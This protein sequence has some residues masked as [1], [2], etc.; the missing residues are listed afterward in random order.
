[1]ADKRSEILHDVSQ[2]KPLS[3]SATALLDVASKEEHDLQ[4]LVNIV[5]HDAT[6]T[7]EIL[8]VVNSAAYGFDTEITAIDRAISFTGE[9]A[10]VSLAMKEAAAI[11]F[12]TDLSGYAGQKGDLWDH[13]LFTA[14]AAKQVAAHA[15]EPL[16]GEVAFTCGLLHDFGKAIL[17]G[18]LA[19]TADKVVLALEKGK[20]DD[21]AAAEEKILGMDHCQAGYE[22]ARHWQLPEPLPSVLRYHHEPA[23]APENCRA[24]V[25]AVHLGDMLAMMSGRS[26]GA[27]SMHYVLDKKYSDHIALAEDDL[28][29]IILAVD[30][31][32]LK[33][34]ESME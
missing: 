6:L 12:A 5:K 33:I 19:N 27:D 1:M 11:V 34:K 3:P 28:A 18:F 30:E 24:L 22:L 25:Y 15:V 2:I 20:V 31:Q 29:M 9:D 23:L 32:F 17:S 4:D 16:N 10:L 7:M 26:T 21:Y 14:L 8:K 13:N